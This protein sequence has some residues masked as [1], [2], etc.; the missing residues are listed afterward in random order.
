MKSLPET[1][2]GHRK[3]VY[4]SQQT[5][6]A[7]DRTAIR[8]PEE[9]IPRETKMKVGPTEAESLPIGGIPDTTSERSVNNLKVP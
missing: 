3:S 6:G 2:S 1:N 5:A 4:R 7:T 9:L 8:L